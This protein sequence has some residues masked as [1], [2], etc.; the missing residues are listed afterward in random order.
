AIGG[1]RQVD[2]VCLT[3]ALAPVNIEAR[4]G[5][6]GDICLEL[7]VELHP[8]R[9]RKPTP[10]NE[11]EAGIAAD[12]FPYVALAAGLDELLGGSSI[13]I[14]PPSPER[15]ARVADETAK[16]RCRFKYSESSGYAVHLVQDEVLA[17]ADLIVLTA[18]LRELCTQRVQLA[19]W[20]MERVEAIDS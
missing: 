18:K 12:R 2:T 7:E 16:P 6:A 3:I 20:T 11:F 19:A 9:R 13:E 10:R 15:P 17:L 4:W 1:P 5:D 8:P 14:E